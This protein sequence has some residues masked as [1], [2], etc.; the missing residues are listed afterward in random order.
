MTSSV[1]K[2]RRGRSWAGA[3]PRNGSKSGEGLRVQGALSGLQAITAD[4]QQGQDEITGHQGQ[5]LVYL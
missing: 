5:S 3:G 4:G 1:A 2:S